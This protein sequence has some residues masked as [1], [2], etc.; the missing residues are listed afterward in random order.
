MTLL[1]SHFG[2]K[3][4]RVNLV[5]P[6]LAIIIYIELREFALISNMS[7]RVDEVPDHF[8]E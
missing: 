1:F 2:V 4:R 5:P 6:S 3:D 7:S 8:R